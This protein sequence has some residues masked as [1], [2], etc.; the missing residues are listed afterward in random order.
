MKRSL[1]FV[2]FFLISSL[3]SGCQTAAQHA[4]DVQDAQ[5]GDHMTVGKVQREIR[6]GMSS[7]DVIQVLGSPNIV[8]TDDQRREVW[9]YDKISTEKVYSNS[10][11]GINALVLGLGSSLAGGGGG[12]ASSSTGASGTSQ[13]T[14]TV[15]IKFDKQQKVSDFSYHTSRF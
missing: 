11:G 2:V 3:L 9:V 5:G 7:A 13:R 1:V 14:I 12:G 4:K 6:V 8:S 10:S 15:V